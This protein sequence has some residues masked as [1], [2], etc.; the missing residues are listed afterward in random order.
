[1]SVCDQEPQSLLGAWQCA[2]GCAAGMEGAPGPRSCALAGSCLHQKQALF[3]VALL[4]A[5]RAAFDGLPL[6]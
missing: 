3:R 6:T 4:S 2:D 1:M 5:H